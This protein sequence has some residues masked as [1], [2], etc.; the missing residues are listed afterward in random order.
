MRLRAALTTRRILRVHGRAKCVPRFRGVGLQTH[1]VRI[2]PS[3]M[4]A[5]KSPSSCGMSHAGGDGGERNRV[6][7]TDG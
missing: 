1:G 7:A 5:G 6:L 4:R 3:R 2:V